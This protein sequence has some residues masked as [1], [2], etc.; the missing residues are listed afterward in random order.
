MF[1]SDSEY[2]QESIGI[3]KKFADEHNDLDAMVFLAKNGINPDIYKHKIFLLTE[4]NNDPDLRK[5]AAKKLFDLTK[6]IG[7]SDITRERIP[8]FKKKASK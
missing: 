8:R 6:A 3:M 1:L 4:E 5:E 2:N 7:E